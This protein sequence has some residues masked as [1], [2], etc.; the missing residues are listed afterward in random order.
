MKFEFC[1]LFSKLLGINFT[2]IFLYQV[3]I[4]LDM[5]V[6]YITRV[7]LNNSRHLF[8]DLLSVWNVICMV[9]FLLCGTTACNEVSLGLLQFL[10]AVTLCSHLP[11]SH[12]Q[13]IC[14]IPLYVIS[15][16]GLSFSPYSAHHVISLFQV[17]LIYCRHIC[18]SYSHITFAYHRL[19]KLI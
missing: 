3:S 15:P 10:P 9:F 19:F 14:S 8:W 2:Y 12:P 11:V 4:R 5:C 17:T 16:T 13:M 18:D 7:P 1:L 6:Y